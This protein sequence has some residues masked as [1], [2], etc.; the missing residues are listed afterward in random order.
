[1]LLI[2]IVQRLFWE[3][4]SPMCATARM[5]NSLCLNLHPNV[6][7]AWPETE[8]A[9]LERLHWQNRLQSI[10][11][12]PTLGISSVIALE[13]V[14]THAR[15]CLSRTGEV[16]TNHR[17][18]LSSLRI[19]WMMDCAVRDFVQ[20]NSAEN[21]SFYAKLITRTMPKRTFYNENHQEK[22]PFS[23]SHHTHER[24]HSDVGV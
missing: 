13:C 19:P 14:P 6:T 10:P 24:D 11:P 22:I 15:F 9:L 16:D 3:S 21:K 23:K 2:T 4:L 20:Q 12:S 18:V 7:T 17:C 8:S 5:L 1:M